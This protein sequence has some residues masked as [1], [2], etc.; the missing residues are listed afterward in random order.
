MKRVLAALAWAAA[1]W[2]APAVAQD[3]I[4]LRAD[5]VP[6]VEAEINGRA[7]QLEVDLRFPRGLALS[8]EAA[9]RL[10]VRRVP[11]LAAQVGIEGGEASLRGRIARP[12]VVFGGEEATR[13]F[14]GVFPTPVTHR[15]DGV[16]GPGVLPY[17]VITIE[18][19]PRP[20]NGRDIVFD[21]RDPDRWEATTRVGGESVRIQ[22]DLG[23]RETVFNR[24]A[25]RLFDAAG[26][27]PATG[28]VAPVMM[29]LGLSTLMQPVDTGLSVEGLP[30]S[31]AFARTNAPLLGASE[32]DAVVVVAEPRDPPPPTITLGREALASCASIHVDRRTRRMTLHCAA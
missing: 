11:L 7:V 10:R 26:A 28:A 17:D 22:F 19:G 5:P 30:L 2:S 27:I 3:A 16:V 32:E 14:T 13:A 31:A 21:L 6:I 15:A 20:A 23:N 1:M 25:T 24:S 12:R 8:N 4:T 9:Q 29:I 18:I